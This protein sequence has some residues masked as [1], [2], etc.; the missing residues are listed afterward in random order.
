MTTHN[1]PHSAS[2]NYSYF[3][4]DLSTGRRNDSACFAFSPQG[5]NIQRKLEGKITISF[6]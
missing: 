6:Q 4:M 3:I 1:A 5:Q 2:I